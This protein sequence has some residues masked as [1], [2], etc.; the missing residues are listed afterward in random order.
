MRFMPVARR[1][2]EQDAN[3][4]CA[5]SAYCSHHSWTGRR[6]A[7]S[8]RTAVTPSGEPNTTCASLIGDDLGKERRKE[9][10]KVEL[11]PSHTHVEVRSEL[12]PHQIEL[13][14]R[15]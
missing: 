1:Q 13:A 14:V 9:P 10:W 2:Y 12:H 8:I 15:T 7:L 5:S 4:E 3:V 11:Q 6:S